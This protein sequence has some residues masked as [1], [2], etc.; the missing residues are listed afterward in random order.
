M[1]ASSIRLF[2]SSFRRAAG[3]ISPGTWAVESSRSRGRQ[4]P[5][6]ALF[7]FPLSLSLSHSSHALSPHVD[8]TAYIV[9]THTH[10]VHI[11]THTHTHIHTHFLPTTANQAN[12]TYAHHHHH[13]PSPSPSKRTSQ[14]LEDPLASSVCSSYLPTCCST[15]ATIY[16]LRRSRRWVS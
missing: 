16:P 11:H 6:I 7:P 3:A 4:D 9:H 10:I 8:R 2:V 15:P 12:Y 1:T 14:I 13:L 5:S